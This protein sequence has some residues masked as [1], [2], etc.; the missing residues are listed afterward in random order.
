[1]TPNTRL[2]PES[3]RDRS[4]RLKK[5]LQSLSQERY[6]FV[7]TPP[8]DVGTFE[9][10]STVRIRKK[11]L[12]FDIWERFVDVD[13]R[14]RL[15]AFCY[16]L[17]SNPDPDSD[18]LFRYECHPDTGEPVFS[19]AAP[20]EEEPAVNYR[21]SYGLI[22]HFHPRNT[23]AFPIS[24]LHYPFQRAHRSSVIFAL[25]AWMRTDLVNRYYLA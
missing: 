13:S 15:Y 9:I 18:P 2:N 20:D 3:L 6:V 23:L 21:S 1:M 4:T 25:I 10:S 24:R 22:P 8:S 19:D 7:K 11:E 16:R 17:R 14:P 5:A 12:Y